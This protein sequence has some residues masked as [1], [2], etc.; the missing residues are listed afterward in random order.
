[1]MSDGLTHDEMN[2]VEVVGATLYLGDCLAGLRG[3][4]DNSVDAIVTDPPYG[5]SFMGKKWDYDVPPEEVWRECLRVLKP[6]GH[7]LAFAGTRTQHRMAVRIED[8]GFEI[9]D[10]IAWVYGSGFPKS[11]DV[12]KAIDKRREEDLEPAAVVAR[13]LCDRMDERGLTRRDVSE[14]FGAANIAQQWTTHWTDGAVKPRVPKWDQWQELRRWLDLPDDMDAEV[15]RL[16]GRKGKPGDNFEAREVLSER[17]TEVKGGSWAEHV[18]SGRFRVGEKVIR[19]TAPATDAARQWQGWGTALKPALEPITVARKPLE[20]TVAAN[21]LAHGTGALNIDGCR[22]GN[23]TISQHGRGDSE[24]IAMSGRNYAEEAGRSWTGRWP[25]NLIHDGSDEVVGLFPESSTTG[26]RSAASRA[27]TVEGTA[28]LADNHQSTEY[29]DSGSA[30]RFFY[31][32]KASKKDRGDGNTHPTVKPT[33]LMRYLCRLVTPPGGVVLDPFMGSGS[34]GKAA[35]LEGFRFIGFE[36]SPEYH[37]IARL[38]IE[39]V[40]RQ[41]SLIP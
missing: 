11:L 6:G 20:G 35:A 37:A 17:I 23:E 1:M 13:W 10:M 21:V 9:R 18:D 8:A 33:D 15:W 30:A 27:A 2:R 4:P 29:T 5:L 38:R 39:S 41:M 25:A 19:E 14:H 16:N 12:S 32:A 24:N 3:L 40:K 28:W 36:I 31:C 22:V 34:T 7:L 26:K